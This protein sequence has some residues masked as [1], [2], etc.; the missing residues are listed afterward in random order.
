M[1]FIISINASISLSVMAFQQKIVHYQ[2]STFPNC[3]KLLWKKRYG[4]LPPQ[5]AGYKYRWIYWDRAYG[6]V[7]L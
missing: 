6:S 2:L 4:V 3:M 5:G 1:N 7:Y